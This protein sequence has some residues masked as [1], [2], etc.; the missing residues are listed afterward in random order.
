[1]A[2]S[3]TQKLNRTELVDAIS[4]SLG[5]SKAQSEK[6]LNSFVS[7]VTDS[8]AKGVEVNITGFGVFRRVT[9]S[10]RMGV[11]PKSRLPMQIPASTSVAYKV[12]KTLKEAVK[13]SK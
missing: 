6:F 3:T 10:A 12:G 1:M 8:L 9:R 2:K 13:G 5:V 7:V 11:N 4:V